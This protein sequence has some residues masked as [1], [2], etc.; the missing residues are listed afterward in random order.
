M[1]SPAVRLGAM[2]LR[3]GRITVSVGVSVYPEAA[4]NADE[5][6]DQADQAMYRAKELGKNRVVLYKKEDSQ[7]GRGE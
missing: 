3:F 7:V 5:L 4:T 2:P 1:T 6:F